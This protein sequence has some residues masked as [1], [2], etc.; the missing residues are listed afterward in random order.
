MKFLIAILT[1]IMVSHVHAKSTDKILVEE[2]KIE[3]NYNLKP[4]Y[5]FQEMI[6]FEVQ[7]LKS[8]EKNE[9]FEELMFG[10]NVLF[11]LLSSEEKARM[12][13]EYLSHKKCSYQVIN[14]DKKYVYE[15]DK[16][17]NAG[18][19]N[20]INSL[21]EKCSLIEEISENSLIV[22]IFYKE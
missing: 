11:Y 22:K 2:K 4:N 20:D 9:C 17:I 3:L 19:L 12:W 16:E 1:C 7:S 5:D 8:C 15:M 13:N 21:Y 6:Q 18:Q 14:L 10:N